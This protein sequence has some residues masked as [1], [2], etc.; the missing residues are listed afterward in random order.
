[1]HIS[2]IESPY[3]S[4]AATTKFYK[5]H[6]DSQ[7][8]TFT[9]ATTQQEQQNTAAYTMSLNVGNIEFPNVLG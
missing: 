8:T 6:Q 2:F 3:L 1:M 9:L 4:L 5:R 7:L